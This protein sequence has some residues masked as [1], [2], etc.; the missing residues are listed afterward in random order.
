MTNFQIRAVVA[1]NRLWQCALIFWAATKNAAHNVR[2]IP[3]SMRPCK[4]LRSGLIWFGINSG[5]TG[6][7]PFNVA[8]GCV[9]QDRKSTFVVDLILAD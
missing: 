6:I 3:Q 1:A 9:V 4:G 7:T 5:A 2:S 8:Q